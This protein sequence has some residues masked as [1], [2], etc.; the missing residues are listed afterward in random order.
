[1]EAN[2]IEEISFDYTDDNGVPHVDAFYTLS[3]EG[4]VLGYIIKGEFYPCNPNYLINDYIM[5]VIKEYLNEQK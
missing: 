5:S 4:K 1:M 2:N 3:E